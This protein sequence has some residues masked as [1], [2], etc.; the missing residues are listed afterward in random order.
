MLDEE[1][2]LELKKFADELADCAREIVSAYHAKAFTEI[3]TKPDGS[4]V[5]VADKECERRLRAMI[6]ERYPD[7]GIIGEEFGNENTDAEFVW[8]LDPIDGTKSFVSRVAL[9]GILFGVLH[10]GKPCIGVIDQPISRERI[11]GDGKSAFYNGRKVQ[12]AGT[13]NVEE[14]LL[15]TTDLI[16]CEKEHPQ[17]NWQALLH[18]AKLFRTWGDCYAYMMVANGRADIMADPVLSPWDLYPLLPILRGAGA[19][20]SDWRGN[21]PLHATSILAANPVL[22]EKALEILAN[23]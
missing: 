6:H 16:D 19:V 14:A 7:H 5:T 8:S 2:I 17:E 22:H 9:Y 23:R 10:E 4:P 21:D 13:R 18:R 20:V 12:V 15:L 3:E 1:K 11:V